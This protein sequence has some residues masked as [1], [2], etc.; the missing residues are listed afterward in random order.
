MHEERGLAEQRQGR[1]PGGRPTGQ[2][3][4]AVDIFT[5]K[6]VEAALVSQ[7]SRAVGHVKRLRRADPNLSRDDLL[8]ALED[9]FYRATRRSGRAAGAAVSSGTASAISGTRKDTLEAAVFYVLAA[10]EAYEIPLSEL[11]YREG[12]VRAVLLA[13][14]ADWLVNL[15][16]SKTAPHWAGKF[17]AWLPE[18]ATRRIGRINDV[19]GPEFVTEQGQGGIVLEKVV[20]REVGSAFGWLTNTTFAWHVIRVTKGAL[21]D[22]ENDLALDGDIVGEDDGKPDD[23]GSGTPGPIGRSG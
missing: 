1:R 10:T 5:E 17:V 23:M 15:L 12:V 9:R 2:A 8:K 7:A 14:K 13:K 18:P 11:D 21:N 20:E 19:M 6:T 22:L 16:A 4:A 3:S